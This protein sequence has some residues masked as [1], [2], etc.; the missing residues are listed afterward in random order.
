MLLIIQNASL[1]ESY[2]TAVIKVKGF[3]DF[4]QLT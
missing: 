4:Y 3:S 1:K 2:L